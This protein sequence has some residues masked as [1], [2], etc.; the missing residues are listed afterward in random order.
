[1]GDIVQSVD[2]EDIEKRVVR[3]ARY[4]AASTNQW[5]GYATAQR[6]L[7]GPDGSVATLVVSHGEGKKEVKLER[8]ASYSELIRQGQRSGDVVKLLDGNIGYADLDRLKPDQVDSMFEKFRDTRAI[9]FDMRGYLKGTAWSIA[10]RLTDKQD[11]EAAI[12]NGP[13]TMTPDLTNGDIM[14]ASSSYFFV[15]SIPHDDQWKYKG[16]T[17]MLIDER[18]M[19]QAEHTGLFLAAANKTQF[20]GSPTAGANGDVSNFVVPGG[21]TIGFSGHDVRLA[22]GGKLQRLGLQPDVLAVPTLN[23]IRKGRDEVLEKAIEYLSQ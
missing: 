21:I 18:T 8:R 4:L 1:M 13:I 20:I 3:E 15:Q 19:S 17:V 5:L 14:N 2:G 6:V 7:N 12:F 16:K 10:P 23:G 22:S 11:V 9:I